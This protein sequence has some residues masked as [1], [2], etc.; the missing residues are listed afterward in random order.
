MDAIMNY[1]NKYRTIAP[2]DEEKGIVN[3]DENDYIN[4]YFP[5]YIR[6]QH[7]YNETDYL[8]EFFPGYLS[9]PTP[10]PSPAY[11]A[12]DIQ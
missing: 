2:Y 5:E 3:Y 4:D 12:I 11:L 9:N 6:T 10:S 8:N 7:G 1:F